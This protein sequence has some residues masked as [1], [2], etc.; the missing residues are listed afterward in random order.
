M[1]DKKIHKDNTMKTVQN[2]RLRK[3]NKEIEGLWID[4][5]VLMRK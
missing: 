3:M 1:K 5:T 4:L 2:I